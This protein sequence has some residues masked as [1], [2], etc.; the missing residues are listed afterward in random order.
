MKHRYKE[1]SRHESLDT[2]LFDNPNY[3]DWKINVKAYIG[4]DFVLQFV[5]TVMSC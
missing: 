3:L 1:S 5:K 4:S 2:K